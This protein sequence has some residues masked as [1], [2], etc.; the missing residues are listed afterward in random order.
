MLT[1][2]RERG[3]PI[4]VFKTIK[5]FNRVNKEKWF[6][7]ENDDQWSTRRNTEITEITEMTGKGGKARGKSKA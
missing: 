6:E 3:D 4:E 7:F 1:E 5:G 2:R